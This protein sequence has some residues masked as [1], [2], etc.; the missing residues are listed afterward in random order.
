[1]STSNSAPVSSHSTNLLSSAT[2][3]LATATSGHVD[4]EAAASLQIPKAVNNQLDIPGSTNYLY[5]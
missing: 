3:E 4:K 5:C 1:M 2:R